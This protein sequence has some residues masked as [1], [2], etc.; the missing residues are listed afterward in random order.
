M[1]TLSRPMLAALLAWPL[2]TAA[3]AQDAGL[4]ADLDGPREP[5]APDTVL[6]TVAGV[7]IRAS[8]IALMRTQLPQQY[9]GLPADTL[10]DALMEQ[11]V[12]Q[13][14]FAAQLEGTPPRLIVDA[15][16]LEE[17]TLRS[18]Y[19]LQ[20]VLEEATTEEAILE[21]YNETYAD[22]E[23]SREYNAAHILVPTEEEAAEI[24]AELEAGAEFARLAQT[25]STGP[26]GPNGGDLGWFGRGMM[27]PA[28]ETAVAAL[29]VGDISEPVQTQF[30]WHIIQLNDSR[31]SE[32]PP[33]SEVEGEMAEEVQQRA[34][35]TALNAL[36]DNTEVTRLGVRD[37][38]TGF[39]SDPDFLTQ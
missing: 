5:V 28:F 31:L 24:L 13:Q 32:A 11:A 39:L 27:V 15:L 20:S 19:I 23:P 37:V 8:E 16:T 29:E 1:S 38:D 9:Q 30:G 35:E 4:D 2:A 33:L 21:V 10:F 7:D 18:G 34:I 26:S 25:R 17:R 36:L 22:A 12:N 6:A 14:L 3:L